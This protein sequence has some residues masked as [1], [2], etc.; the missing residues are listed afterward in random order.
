MIEAAQDIVKDTRSQ[1]EERIE[2]A[3]FTPKD[4]PLKQNQS[5]PSDFSGYPVP[6]EFPI[7]PPEVPNPCIIHWTE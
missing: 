7:V 5:P 2:R 6:I 4:S 1:H 3:N